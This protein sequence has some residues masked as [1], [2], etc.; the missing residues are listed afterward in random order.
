MTRYSK[1]SRLTTA[2]P[3][4]TL[5]HES[6]HSPSRS[7]S[8]ISM[9]SDT[10]HFY[11][12]WYPVLFGID[13]VRHLWYQKNFQIFFKR[14]IFSQDDIPISEE[15]YEGEFEEEETGRMPTTSELVLFRTASKDNL[16]DEELIQLWRKENRPKYGRRARAKP[17]LQKP[18]GTF[19]DCSCETDVRFQRW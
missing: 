1:T 4:V 2:F 12:N 14:K 6:G 13:E 16:T 9:K 10:L 18:D 8:T 19:Y 3:S 5:F 7:Y 15:E 11:C 17:V